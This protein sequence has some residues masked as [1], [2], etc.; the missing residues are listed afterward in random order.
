[1][2][3]NKIGLARVPNGPMDGRALKGGIT[4]VPDAS[5]QIDARPLRARVVLCPFQLLRLGRWEDE[6]QLQGKTIKDFY[7]FRNPFPVL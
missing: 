6:G 2:T 7:P 3:V 5:D 4:H 1:M